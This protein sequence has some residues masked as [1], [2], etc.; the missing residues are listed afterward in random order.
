MCTITCYLFF[1]DCGGYYT[2]SSGYIASPGYPADYMDSVSCAYTIAQPVG[3]TI[4][5]S[6]L[7]LAIELYSFCEADY[8]EVG[9]RGGFCMVYGETVTLDMWIDDRLPAIVRCCLVFVCHLYI[10]T[11]ALL[12]IR[13]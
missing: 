6:V 1:P 13:L 11:L 12:G 7:V 10:L 3:T 9:C 8:L 2:W 5:L 4:H